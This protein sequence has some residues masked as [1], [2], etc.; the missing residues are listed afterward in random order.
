MY[1]PPKYTVST[2]GEVIV[3]WQFNASFLEDAYDLPN[4]QNTLDIAFYD[5]NGV[6]LTFTTQYNFSL[7]LLTRDGS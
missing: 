4:L 2:N 6:L 7:S 1:L 5:E 3:Q